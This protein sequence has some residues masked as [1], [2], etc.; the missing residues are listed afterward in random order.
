ML[1]SPA[2][3]DIPWQELMLASHHGTGTNIPRVCQSNRQSA[4]HNRW[5]TRNR[6]SHFLTLPLLDNDYF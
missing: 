2:K 6:F 3:E 1:V 4:M 5:Q